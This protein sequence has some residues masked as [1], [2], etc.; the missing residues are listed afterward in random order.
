MGWGSHGGRAAAA[1]ALGVTTETVR[2]YALGKPLPKAVRLAMAAVCE[3]LS[4]WDDNVQ[5]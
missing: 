5:A 3:S 4:P 2:A 1:D